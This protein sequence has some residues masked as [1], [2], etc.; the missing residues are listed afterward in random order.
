MGR[1]LA[2]I[3]FLACG[4]GAVWADGDAIAQRREMM[5]GDGAAIKQILG[6]L[7]GG[8]PFDLATVQTS[9]K[10]FVVAAAKSPTLFPDDSKTGGGTNAL[11]AIWENK[12]DFD[13]RFA[14]FGKDAAAALTTITDEA[15]FKANIGSV[16]QN[17]GGCHEL[18]KAKSS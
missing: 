15:S 1:W 9:L 17:C 10:T 8:A 14:T 4:L 7:K 11:P 6:M 13:A 18:Y 2:A 12:A 3:L 16:L 5:K